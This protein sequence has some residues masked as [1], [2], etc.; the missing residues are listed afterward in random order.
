MD[1]DPR[2]TI[3]EADQLLDGAVMLFSMQLLLL[4]ELLYRRAT[5]GLVAFRVSVS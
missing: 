3:I 4:S 1:R 2:H 5:Q